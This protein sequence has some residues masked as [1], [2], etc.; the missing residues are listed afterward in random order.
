M[1]VL[2]G[3]V[4]EMIHNRLEKRSWKEERSCWPDEEGLW[5]ESFCLGE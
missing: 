4:E 5:P 1:L 2:A 3:E